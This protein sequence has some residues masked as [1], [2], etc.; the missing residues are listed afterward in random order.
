MPQLEGELKIQ[1]QLRERRLDAVNPEI[2]TKPELNDPRNAL[3]ASREAYVEAMET[4]AEDIETIKT[5]YLTKL[6]A[7]RVALKDVITGFTAPTGREEEF[8]AETQEGMIMETVFDE[9]YRLEEARINYRL[10]R[11]ER[12]EGRSAK[13]GAKIRNIFESTVNWYAKIPT[14]KKLLL[15]LGVSVVGINAAAVGGA[16]AAVGGTAALAIG[17]GMRIL[18]DSAAA[19]AGAGI[20]KRK[21][22]TRQLGADI[23]SAHTK[24][25]EAGMEI[26]VDELV[27]KLDEAL[28]DVNRELNNRALAIFEAKK[29]QHRNLRFAQVLGAMAGVGV[30]EALRYG[31]GQILEHTGAGEWLREKLTFIHPD[32][33]PAVAPVP[34]TVEEPYVEQGPPVPEHASYEDVITG[35]KGTDWEFKSLR[36]LISSHSHELGY[37]SSSGMSEQQWVDQEFHRAV[38]D[39]QAKDQVFNL[40]HH[41]DK[42]VAD[43]NDATGKYEY[44]FQAGSQAPAH[45]LPHHHAASAPVEEAPAAP[46]EAPAPAPEPAGPTANQ[47][48][49]WEQVQSAY[50]NSMWPSKGAHAR[51]ALHELWSQIYPEQAYDR[52]VVRDIIRDLR[53]GDLQDIGSY[54]HDEASTAPAAAVSAEGASVSSAGGGGAPVAETS[55]AAQMPQAPSAPEPPQ[56]PEP[57]VAPEA[58]L[59]PQA[60]EISNTTP[61]ITGD[62]LQNVD[63]ISYHRLLE[64]EGTVVESTT[65]VAKV[66][67]SDFASGE[68]KLH[69]LQ[70]MR[71]VDV[72]RLQGMETTA[73]QDVVNGIENGHVPLVEINGHKLD[74]NDPKMPTS[75]EVSKWQ[76]YL[77][78]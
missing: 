50:E 58:P 47:M 44:H 37:D 21:V 74:F 10:A 18:G 16:V 42:V 32:T 49:A 55:P 28:N 39:L 60:V 66:N 45:E 56:P 19:Y 57:P 24:S 13:M 53:H 11:T 7:Y 70:A 25:G 65:D 76:T 63:S 62:N 51:E 2:L 17:T 68:D 9:A 29:T 59:P 69:A 77:R 41:G 33:A 30:A 48:Q 75:F 78:G 6:S 46:V 5:E 14:R 64:S 22:R 43:W 52:G 61:S 4:N 26:N 3:I 73:I 23:E 15:A 72:A 27:Q 54:L 40:T 36:D 20:A 38:A 34:A 1:K 8:K 31:I 12:T 35:T 67:L 71:A